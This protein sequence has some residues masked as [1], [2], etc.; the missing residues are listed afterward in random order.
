VPS[1]DHL[2]REGRHVDHGEEGDHPSERQH[3]AGLPLGV[4]AGDFVR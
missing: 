1:A 2:P 4:A 3:G